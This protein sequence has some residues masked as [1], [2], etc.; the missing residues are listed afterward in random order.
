MSS[1]DTSFDRW[2]FDRRAFAVSSKNG[3]SYEDYYR[4]MSTKTN[5]GVIKSVPEW[6]NNDDKLAIVIRYRWRQFKRGVYLK[7]GTKEKIANDANVSRAG[8]YMAMLAGVA[9]RSWRL[10]EDAPTVAWRMGMT[11]S[12]VRQILFRMKRAAIKLGF[13]EGSTS[14]LGWQLLAMRRKWKEPE[15]KKRV[16]E[17]HRGRQHSAETCAKTSAGR[18]RCEASKRS[19]NL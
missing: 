2:Q 10:H 13:G 17:A 12:N 6:A 15:Y 14:G 3:I 16:R 19:T 7:E 4:G 1:F 5:R 9:Y 11:A 18:R 8:S